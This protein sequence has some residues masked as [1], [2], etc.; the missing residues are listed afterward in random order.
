MTSNKIVASV[1]RYTYFC[2]QD[3]RFSVVTGPTGI[4]GIVA[5]SSPDVLVVQIRQMVP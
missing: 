5:I 2:K 3:E 4:M 1:A